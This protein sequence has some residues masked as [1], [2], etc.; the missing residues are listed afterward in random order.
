MQALDLL[1]R[2]GAAFVLLAT[3]AL[4]LR[5]AR[6]ERIVWWFVPFAL[7]LCGFLARNTPDPA[8]LP[9]GAAAALASFL[10]GNAAI[11]LWW[12]CLAL[13]DD[14]FRPGA[15]EG[16][17][18]AAWCALALLDRGFLG[19]RAAGLGLG[20][21]LIGLG[22]LI[23]AHLAWR[24]LRDR[25]GDLVEP[26]RR[27]RGRLVAALAALLLVD[28]GV[29]VA[30]GVEWRPRGFCMLQN[31]AIGLLA[32]WIALR[33]LRADAA[34]LAFRP[35]AAAAP[36]RPPVARDA[37]AEA[38]LHARLRT[39]MTVE[40]IHRDPGLT[41]AGF[42]ARMG[43]PAPEVRRFVNHALG[44]RHFRAFLNAYRL[45]DARA[46]LADPA[47][48]RRKLVA[49]ALDSGFASLAS[50]TRT[51]REAEGVSPGEY[52][53]RLHAAAAPGDAPAGQ[54]T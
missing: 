23:V 42:A 36:G 54:D 33:S 39:L 43:A 17:V 13:F 2:A 4:L 22:A 12:F 49:V 52:R 3:C 45:A 37:G 29:D 21:W 31:A 20:P 6:R 18:G 9:T 38:H 44:A 34:R 1:L 35:A 7:G 5:D 15:L 40:R 46:A 32:A 50:F 27:L 51:F 41:F 19:E 53:R 8:L 10:S 26:R 47:Q 25:E 16:G 14:D 24:L 28:L 48:A 11:A 30:M